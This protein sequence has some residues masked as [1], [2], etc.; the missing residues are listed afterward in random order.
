MRSSSIVGFGF[1]LSVALGSIGCVSSGKY[2][3]LAAE[4]AKLAVAVVELEA[5]NQGLAA[6]LSNS[7]TENLTMRGTYDQLLVEL[8]AEVSSGQIEI[9]QLID[10]IQLNVSDQLLFDSGS[11]AL[12]EAG[13]E[14]IG[15]VAEQVRDERTVIDVEGHTDTDQIGP[16]L[17]GR[18]ATNWELAG[19]RAAQVVRQLSEDGVT[20]G[21][22]RAVSRGPFDPIAS[23]DTAEGR[24]KNR[25]TEIVLR[26]MPE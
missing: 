21:R 10:G 16:A 23:N 1:L 2:D 26:P 4:N 8:E 17:R 5:A 12:N 19:A 13:V 11:A 18:F 3:A 24:A 7:V 9:Q 25:R 15:R 6:E 20:P 14:V 22:L